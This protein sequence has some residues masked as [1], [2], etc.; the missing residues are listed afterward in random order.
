MLSRLLAQ[1]Q[2]DSQ[3]LAPRSFCHFDSLD[4]S[5]VNIK[6]LRDIMQ[7]TKKYK[8]FNRIKLMNMRTKPYYLE[9]NFPPAW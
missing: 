4:F 2:F 9:G 8:L 3:G 5:P 7:I 6:L 1:P